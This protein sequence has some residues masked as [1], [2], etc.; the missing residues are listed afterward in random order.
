MKD[1]RCTACGTQISKQG[2]L[3]LWKKSKAFQNLVDREELRRELA[4]A[5]PYITCFACDAEDN[6]MVRDDLFDELRGVAEVEGLAEFQQ[7]QMYADY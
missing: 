1:F 2:I 3:K 4:T 5:H 6:V 7:E